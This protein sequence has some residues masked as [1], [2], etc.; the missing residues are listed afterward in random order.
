MVNCNPETVSTDYDISDRLYFEPLDSESVLAICQAENINNKLLG[1][2]VQLGGQT[3]L[4]LSEKLVESDIK[5]LGTSFKS[6]DLCE[7]RDRFAKLMK[8]LNILQPKSDIVFNLSEAKK[9]IKSIE[10]PIVIRP[11]YVLGGRAMMIINNL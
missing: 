5:I 7:D 4:K 11:S 9:A 3:P 6:I 8:D 1:V 10:F 2:I